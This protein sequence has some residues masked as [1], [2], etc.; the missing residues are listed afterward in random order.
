VQQ[1]Q[2][3]ARHEAVVDEGVFLDAQPFV[4]ALQVT[5]ARAGA[6]IGSACTKPSR[7]IAPGSVSGL[8]RLRAI[9]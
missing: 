5:G 9:A 4:A 6:R 7:R 8:N 3:V 2:H 1:R